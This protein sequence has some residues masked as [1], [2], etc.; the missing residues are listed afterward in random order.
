MKTLAVIMLGVILSIA[1]VRVHAT[2]FYVGNGGSDSNNGKSS[3]QAM[4]TLN[5]AFDSLG[6]GDI[7]YIMGGAYN[8]NVPAE[9]P[10]SSCVYLYYQDGTAANPITVTAYPD[11]SR[12]IISGYN[13]SG[14]DK[15]YHRRGFTFNHS[16][17]WVIDGLEFRNCGNAGI[18]FYHSDFNTVRNCVFD[19]IYQQPGSVSDDTNIGGI[20][21]WISVDY[22]TIEDCTTFAIEHYPGYT[23]VNKSGFHF[24]NCYIFIII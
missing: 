16:D 11:S 17:Y 7:L 18:Y 12:P 24:Y 1:P 19:S 5:T 6:P 22:L 20:K 15:I 8:E 23:G 13:M 9:S 4:R 14:S 10:F 3:L 21:T 2:D